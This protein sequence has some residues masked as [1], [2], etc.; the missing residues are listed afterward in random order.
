MNTINGLHHLA[1]ST[2]DMK[3]QIAFFT[4]AMGMELVALYWMHGARGA[5]HAF[6]RMT[7]DSYVALVYFPENA[8]MKNRIGYTHPG[9]PGGTSAPGTMQHLALKVADM[10]EMLAMRDRLRQRGIPVIG[11]IDHGMCHSMYFAGP[12]NLSLEIACGDEPISAKAWIDPEVVELCGISAA[13]L[14]EFTR[15]AAHAA[16]GQP[17]A[18]PGVDAV[19]PHMVGHADG[20]Y[21]Q[22]LGLSDADVMAVMSKN[23]PPV[24]V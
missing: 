22:M 9:N 16:S 4:D 6:L 1:V 12:E 2:G 11:P 14:A 20:V 13:E 24:R 19:G 21:E 18:Q 8:D 15:P 17:V 7:D 10:D 23:K 5:F 3:K